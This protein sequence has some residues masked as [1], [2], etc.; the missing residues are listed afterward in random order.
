MGKFERQYNVNHDYFSQI[1]TS[2]KA[3][4]LGFIYADGCNYITEDG[5]TNIIN[6]TQ[7]KDSVDILQKIKLELESEYPIL[8]YTQKTN[9]K[10]ICRT[11]IR[12]KQLSD[13][14]IKLG[15]MSKK[16]LIVDFPS[17]TIVPEQ[18]MP[19]F[20]RGYFDGDGCVWDGKRKK[21]RVKDLSKIEGFRDRIIHNVKFTFTGNFNFI[22]TLQDF[23]VINLGFKKTK[24][25]FSKAKETKHICTMEYSGRGQMKTFYDYLYKD[26]TIYSEIKKLKFENIFCA[27]DEKSSSET[28]L[29]AG[30]PETVISSQAQIEMSLKVQRLSLKWEYTQVSGNALP[31]TRNDEGEDIVCSNVKSSISSSLKNGYELTTHIEH[32]GCLFARNK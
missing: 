30:K 3:Y 28:R 5:K 4:I 23:L 31:L 15:V 9:E 16:S 24:L 19:H 14:L 12:S 7:L 26:A 29:I 11:N 1:D 20:I 2:E 10:I 25:N 17:F 6:F 32:K 8:E 21:S 27:L 22:N 18:F 13:D